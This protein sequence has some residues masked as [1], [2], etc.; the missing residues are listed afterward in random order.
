MFRLSRNGELV[1]E[2]I[3]FWNCQICT[4]LIN[5][6][7]KCQS[8]NLLLAEIFT[9]PS[10]DYG[11]WT[12]F[13]IFFTLHRNVVK[14]LFS[15]CCIVFLNHLY[16]P[17]V[18]FYLGVPTKSNTLLDWAIFFFSCSYILGLVHFRFGEQ[19]GRWSCFCSQMPV[20]LTSC[21]T[22]PTAD[23]TLLIIK[24]VI[25]SRLLWSDESELFTLRSSFF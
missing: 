2:D 18:L 25:H 5:C 14:F 11:W 1:S 20:H 3:Y 13:G 16:F 21:C 7:T 23:C 9:Q 24:S 17:R 15:V 22:A 6:L 8:F 10:A 12:L 4:F 19:P